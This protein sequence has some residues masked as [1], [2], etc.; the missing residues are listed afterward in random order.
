[1]GSFVSLRS[2]LCLDLQSPK[3]PKSWPL[4]H[5]HGS[6]YFGH[7][8]GTADSFHGLHWPGLNSDAM[9]VLTVMLEVVARRLPPGSPGSNL[10]RY[11]RTASLLGSALS[12]KSGVPSSLYNHLLSLASPDFRHLGILCFMGATPDNSTLRSSAPTGR[13]RNTKKTLSIRVLIYG[14]LTQCHNFKDALFGKVGH[15]RRHK[16]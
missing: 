3:Y 14:L 15:W 10:L 11:T 7:F 16:C 6:R 4:S 2:I 1:M 5:N 9:F 13:Q 12:G 8:R